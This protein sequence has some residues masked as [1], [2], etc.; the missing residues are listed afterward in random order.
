M[1]LNVTWTYFKKISFFT[2]CVLFVIE[3]IF[4]FKIIKNEIV[5]HSVSGNIQYS[6]SMFYEHVTVGRYPVVLSIEEHCDLKQQKM[7][8]QVFKDVFQ[9]KLLTEPLEPE[10]EQLPS[11]T[12]LRGKIILKVEKLHWKILQC[13]WFYNAVQ[14]HA[15]SLFHT[16]QETEYWW[17]I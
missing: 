12:Q 6:W 4:T 10:A 3:A 17:D 5:A 11:P 1:R 13:L 16:A 9:D 8:A 7:M 14:S 15:I 2:F